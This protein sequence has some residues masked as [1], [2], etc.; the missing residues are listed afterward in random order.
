MGQQFETVTK[1]YQ[2]EIVRSTDEC[3]RLD[4]GWGC[5]TSSSDYG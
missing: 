4:P 2:D 5:Q 3:A 1:Q